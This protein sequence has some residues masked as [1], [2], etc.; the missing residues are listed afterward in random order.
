MMDRSIVMTRT[1]NA[2]RALVWKA[3][4]TPEL[5]ARWFGPHGWGLSISEM[6]FRPG[7]L[8]LYCMHGPADEES[9]GRTVY[10]EI[11]EPERLVYLDYFADASGQ[12]VEGMPEAEVTIEFTEENSK[13]RI[14][15]TVVYPT[16]GDRD[17]I[18][19]MGMVAGL[20]ETM[21]R[22]EGLLQTL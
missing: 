12:P 6:D 5:L 2:P 15:H 8:L 20:N 1:F 11:V 17:R 19:Q 18:L 21:D 9:C 7:G 3:W 10:Q 22:L 4:T 16:I 13:T 14:T